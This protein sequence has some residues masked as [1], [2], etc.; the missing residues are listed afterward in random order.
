MP[1]M[2]KIAL[3]IA[4][5][6]V[7]AF[8]VLAQTYP[9]LN[10]RPVTDAAN[11]I[12]QDREDR[13]NARLL[14]Y[15]RTTGHQLAVVTVASLEDYAI[16]DYSIGLARK[17]KL[18][19]Q[20][21]DDGVLYLIAPNERASRVEVGYG[22]EPILTD[23]DTALMQQGSNDDFRAGDYATGI[24]KVS[25]AIMA[26]TQMDNTAI[27]DLRSRQAAQ[28]K[29][30]ADKFASDVGNFFFTS[31]LVIGGIGVAGGAWWGVTEPGRRRRRR[32]EE[33]RQARLLA[34]EKERR[35]LQAI[36]NQRLT[37][38]RRLAEDRRKR[39]LVQE[40][41]DKLNAMSPGERQRFLAAEAAAVAAA[42]AAEQERLRVQRIRD[43][44][45][46]VRRQ[47]EADRQRAA[48]E[49]SARQRKRDDDDGYGGLVVIGGGGGDNGGINFGGDG[50]DFGGG[51]SDNN[52]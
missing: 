36:E 32:E 21:A 7:L 30:R 39:R 35:R 1:I 33:A 28:A 2:K 17:L 15:E 52:W 14:E 23:A 45:A 16:A 3:A 10:G 9:S 43:E 44:E 18:G 47:A 41:Q 8:P 50:G 46:R 20:D 51:G 19:N 24:E 11:I 37:Q 6:A 13:L 42:V 34:E 12:P 27:A 40:R 31:F 4:A 5:S 25:A 29:A 26:K 49:E 48:D 38:E 22:L